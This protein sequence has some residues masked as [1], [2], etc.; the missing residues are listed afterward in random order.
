[1]KEDIKVQPLVY[2]I[3]ELV[4]VRRPISLQLQLPEDYDWD[5]QTQEKAK[6]TQDKEHSRG[7]ASV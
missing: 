4:N 1:M 3:S 6:Q 5:Q 2:H 7:K